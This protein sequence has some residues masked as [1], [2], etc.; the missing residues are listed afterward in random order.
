MTSNQD[1]PDG[2]DLPS[3]LAV[4]VPGR[5]RIQAPMV[6]IVAYDE[7]DTDE[8]A[9]GL[10]HPVLIEAAVENDPLNLPRLLSDDEW[11]GYLAATRRRLRLRAERGVLRA[12]SADD[13]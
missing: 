10:S 1:G 11:S 13:R 4:P 7:G 8:S 6:R 5:F 12:E 3:V 9:N 2:S